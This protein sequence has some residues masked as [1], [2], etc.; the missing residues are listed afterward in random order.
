[1]KKKWL[2]LLSVFFLIGC[3]KK[4]EYVE[5]TSQ[6]VAPKSEDQSSEMKPEKDHRNSLKHE[7]P[8]RNH[9]PSK[10]V[11]SQRNRDLKKEKYA[12][13]PLWDSH[14]SQKLA[15]YMRQWGDEMGQDY[16]EAYPLGETINYYGYHYPQDIVKNN[17]AFKNNPI[18]VTLS[19][20]GE[21]FDG[22][23]IVAIFSDIESHSPKGAHLYL[24]TLKD[25]KPTILI[26]SQNQG[27]DEN[28][29]Y[30]NETE[31]YELKKNFEAIVMGNGREKSI[32]QS[33]TS[34]PERHSFSAHEKEKINQRFY[35]WATERAKIGNMASSP[36]FFNHGSGGSGD[37]FGQTPDG[38]ILV[39]NEGNPGKESFPIEALGGLLFF[40]ALDG[41]TGHDEKILSSSIAEGYSRNLDPEFPSSKYILGDNGI[42]Y[43]Y[44]KPAGELLGAGEGFIECD[45][46]GTI[47]EIPSKEHF[48]I[49]EDQAAQSKLK[50]LIAEVTD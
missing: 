17:F 29:I 35:D 10:H 1:M 46:L 48:I 49:S 26:T 32:E 36:L 25:G 39:Q 12:H 3:G 20:D 28:L 37:W 50:E 19:K 27:N 31:N 42:V 43:E 34:N 47:S 15:D 24:F 38:K 45:D 11:D 9:T 6:Q 33:K 5:E 23:N 14:K 18:D 21:S 44:K 40:T 16:Q 8:K 22:Y 2:I 41:T 30:F 4:E 13:R 7:K